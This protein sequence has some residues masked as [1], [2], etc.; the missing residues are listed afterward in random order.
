M[1]TS[2]YTNL[3]I[4]IRY[5]QGALET[6]ISNIHRRDTYT[7]L[8]GGNRGGPNTYESKPLYQIEARKGDL[9][10]EERNITLLT[11]IEILLL[12]LHTVETGML[13]IQVGVILHRVIEI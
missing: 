9:N 4:K 8:Y 12:V 11:L 6:N 7:G 3:T 13:K 5:R 10:V 2:E 1:D